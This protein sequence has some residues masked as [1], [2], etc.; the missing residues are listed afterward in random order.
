[1]IAFFDFKLI[2]YKADLFSLSTFFICST[3]ILT[4]VIPF[5]LVF[6]SDNFWTTIHTTYI[7][8]DVKFNNLIYLSVRDDMENKYYSTIANV[9]D[10]TTETLIPSISFES[11]DNNNDDKA[12]QYKINISFPANTKS[13][14]DIKIIL[15]F[16][17]ILSDRFNYLQETMLF[18]HFYSPLDGISQLNVKGDID[19]KQKVPISMSESLY[20]KDSEIL[21]NNTISSAPVDFFSL[22]KNYKYKNITTDYTSKT[23]SFSEV[24]SDMVNIQLIIDIPVYQEILYIA[25][26]IFT[27]KSTW[28]QYVF[29]LV[30]IAFL[31]YYVLMF[32]FNNKLFKATVVQETGE[33][34]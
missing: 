24:S 12:E 9:N 8:P 26:T 30:P 15:L 20:N 10:I 23:Q 32:A 22:Y 27:L 3:I 34:S 17:Y 4:F 6:T 5:F 21:F 2:L 25:S 29:T 13:V 1:M 28:V 11:N 16:D 19:L 18:Y 31:F 7:Q 14:K 33:I